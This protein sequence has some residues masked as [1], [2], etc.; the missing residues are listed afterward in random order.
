VSD[1]ISG[2]VELPEDG[3]FELEASEALSG[4][5]PPPRRAWIAVLM[6]LLSPVAACLY[7]G[8]G[9]LALTFFALQL[10]L[11]LW[12]V[13]GWADSFSGFFIY[14][15]LFIG[16]GLAGMALTGI[17]AAR[18]RQP[19]RLARYQRYWIYLAVIIAIGGG[20]RL[21]AAVNGP[22]VVGVKSSSLFPV[23][24]SG[25]LVLAV[26]GPF[27]SYEPARGD[28]VVYWHPKQEGERWIKRVI[29]LPGDRLDMVDGHISINGIPLQYRQEPPLT[30]LVR[31]DLSFTFSRLLESWPK[32]LDPAA[33]S[34]EMVYTGLL[35]G[36][37]HNLSG[38]VVPEGHVFVMG[39]YRD[40]S[41][42]SRTSMH[43]PLPIANITHRVVGLLWSPRREAFLRDIYASA[44]P[45]A[46]VR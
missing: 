5:V 27:T 20:Q 23:A 34:H 18:H 33:R 8:R 26:G 1:A 13:A 28:I 45:S 32:E 44:A 37:Y 31:E 36:N 40:N 30:W 11:A 41:L 21:A 39:D 42:D 46:P 9:R 22:A 6:A 29:G 12:L 19:V 14:L 35:T 16:Q 15:G 25:D 2:T 43:G 7:V 4:Q 3:V 17:L 38:Y 10:F 24:W